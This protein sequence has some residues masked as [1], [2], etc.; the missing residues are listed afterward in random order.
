MVAEN[1][2]GCLI[3]YQYANDEEL[4]DYVRGFTLDGQTYTFQ[5]DENQTVTKILNN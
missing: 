2:D 1:R 5:K 4:G 3:S